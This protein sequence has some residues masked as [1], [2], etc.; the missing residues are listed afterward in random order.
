MEFVEE[1]KSADLQV[2][3]MRHFLIPK[4]ARMRLAAVKGE[5]E[6]DFVI[7]GPPTE[8]AFLAMICLALQQRGVMDETVY[9]AN[10]LGARE[11]KIEGGQ[12]VKLMPETE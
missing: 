2:G 6:E 10:E 1:L 7:S 12:V 11:K 4:R 8:S 3:E 9:C 5:N